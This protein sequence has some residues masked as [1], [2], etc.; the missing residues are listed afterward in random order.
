MHWSE[1]NQ[2]LQLQ[3]LHSRPP[4]YLVIHLGSNDLT[5]TTGCELEHKVRGDIDLWMSNLPNTTFIFSELLPRLS[6]G[7]TVIPFQKIEKK[8]K[9]FNNRMRR[10]IHAKGGYF[11]KH[12]INIDTPGMYFRD[13]VH[14]SDV[15]YDM[16][17]LSLTSLFENIS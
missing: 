3:C 17:L 10:F 15:G 9:H 1:F 13:G 7:S 5:S 8:R 6:W 11:V 12:D 16:F 14:L 2:M 4:K